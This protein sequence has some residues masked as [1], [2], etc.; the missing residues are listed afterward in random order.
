MRKTDIVL[1]RQSVL[2][3]FANK[4]QNIYN[5]CRRKVSSDDPEDVVHLRQVTEVREVNFTYTSSVGKTRE[6]I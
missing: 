1:R 3:G 4:P 5:S 6:R 2:P